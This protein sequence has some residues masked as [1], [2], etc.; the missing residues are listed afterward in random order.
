MTRD[1]VTVEEGQSLSEA[2][3]LMRQ[4][5]IRHLP[6]T[7]RGRL[8]G[9]LSQRDILLLLTL[10]GV[11]A[12]QEPVEEAMT[13]APYAVPPDVPLSEALTEMAVRGYGSVVV[14]APDGRPLGIIT[15]RDAL[16]SFARFLDSSVCVEEAA[17]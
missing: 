3:A 16:R 9:L 14:A 11:E 2:H 5:G 10:S 6:V 1:P 12:E 7:R 15:A 4:Y 13:E 17:K 8:S